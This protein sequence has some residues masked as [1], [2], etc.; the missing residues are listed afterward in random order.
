[1][2]RSF[3]AVTRV[4]I[5]SG[6]PNLINDL[7]GKPICVARHRKYTL[8]GRIIPTTL[9]CAARLSVSYAEIISEQK[10]GLEITC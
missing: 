9:L 3:T 8:L 10:P 4:Q 5:P 1:M 7:H 6:T 2:G